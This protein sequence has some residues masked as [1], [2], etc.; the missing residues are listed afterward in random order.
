MNLGHHHGGQRRRHCIHV[1]GGGPHRLWNFCIWSDGCRV[2]ALRQPALRIVLQRSSMHRWQSRKGPGL[3]AKSNSAGGRLSH[4]IRDQA[5]VVT[6]S[7]LQPAWSR[8]VRT[9]PMPWGVGVQAPETG[10]LLASSLGQVHVPV[11]CLPKEVFLEADLQ[12]VRLRSRDH[13]S[14]LA[15][16]QHL[17]G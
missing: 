3:K 7:G 15:G 17:V 5:Q 6:G 8:F 12:G 4:Q 14:M 16:R 13:D 2:H 1:P 10:G 11:S 9:S